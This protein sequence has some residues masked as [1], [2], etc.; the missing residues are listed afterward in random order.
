MT[1]RPTLP[2]NMGTISFVTRYDYVRA[3]I[4]GQWSISPLAPPGSGSKR[5]DPR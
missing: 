1:W 2:Q 3:K 4:D 5:H